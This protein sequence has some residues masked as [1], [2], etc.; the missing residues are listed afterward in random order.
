MLSL[1]SLTSNWLPLAQEEAIRLV[2]AV[3][4][5]AAEEE[6]ALLQPACFH[7]GC[8]G[9]LDFLQ[10]AALRMSHSYILLLSATLPT[11]TFRDSSKVCA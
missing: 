10:V 6:L 11:R 2:Q 7:C 8:S 9:P 4:V 5:D 1:Y 3:C